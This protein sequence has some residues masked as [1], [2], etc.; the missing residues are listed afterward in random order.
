MYTYIVIVLLNEC[1]HKGHSVFCEPYI[2]IHDKANKWLINQAILIVT[3]FKPAILFSKNDKVKGGRISRSRM[4]E[5]IRQPKLIKW[6]T[7]H[8]KDRNVYTT[9]C[10][11]PKFMPIH[12]T[13][14]PVNI[15]KNT[16][17][18]GTTSQCHLKPLVIQPFV[19]PGLYFQT[20]TTGLPWLCPFNCTSKITFSYSLI[21]LEYNVEG[22]IDT[23]WF[24]TDDNTLV[25]TQCWDTLEI[26]EENGLF[27]NLGIGIQLHPMESRRGCLLN[28]FSLCVF[29]G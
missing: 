18:L 15:G 10:V 17:M 26:K 25:S 4:E 19:R 5:C 12:L 3:K 16:L 24:P 9:Q 27:S 21:L 14:S 7:A 28:P 1:Q 22:E 13:A 11:N 8:W 23:L 6:A 20:W 29:Y 2:G